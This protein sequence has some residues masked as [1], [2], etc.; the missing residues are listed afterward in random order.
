MIPVPFSFPEENSRA[1]LLRAYPREGSEDFTNSTPRAHSQS[2]PKRTDGRK[3]SDNHNPGLDPA[4]MLSSNG[5]PA[6]LM[7]SFKVCPVST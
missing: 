3:I 5:A 1:F 4:T 6:R 2:L 7:S